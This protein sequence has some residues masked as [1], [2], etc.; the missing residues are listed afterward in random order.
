MLNG[1]DTKLV[2]YYPAATLAGCV[3][4]WTFDGTKDILTAPAQSGNYTNAMPG[5]TFGHRLTQLQFFPYA[6]DADAATLW[7]KVTAIKITGQ[8]TTCTFTPASADAT[9]AVAF[10]GNASALT[11]AGG[12]ATAPAVGTAAATRFGEPMMVEPQAGSYELTVTVTTENGERTMK[13]PAR[14]YPAGVATKVY[15]KLTAYSIE[16]T[17][18]ITAWGTAGSGTGTGD[19]NFD[20]ELMVDLSKGGTA[21]CYIA[22]RV[23]LEYSFDATKQGNGINT[24][25]SAMAAIAPKSAKVFWQTGKVIEDGSVRLENG[26]VKF[27][28]DPEFKPADGGSALIAV[29]DDIDPDATGAKILWSWHIWATDYNPDGTADYGLAANS[30]AYVSGG[31][32]HTYGTTYMATNPGKVMMDRNLGAEKALYT[33]ATGSNDNWPTYGFLYQWGRK[34]PFPGAAKNVT[35]NSGAS[36]PLYAADGT[37]DI[38]SSAF[39]IVGGSKSIADAV[40]NPGTFYSGSDWT[41][42]N[43]N[44]WSSTTGK[45]TAYDPCPPGWRMALGGTWNDFSTANF[46]ANGSGVTAG[47]FYAVGNIRMWY[48][49]Q[50]YRGSS[51]GTLYSVGTEGSVWSGSI[52]GSAAWDFW[53]NLS[54][55]QSKGSGNRATSFPLRCIQE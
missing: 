22:N 11:V 31:Q 16:P 3:V 35:G 10:S 50:G 23:G 51:N 39:K 42:R 34:D 47:R 44:L 45:K 6:T 36:R 29:Y 46:V 18:E 14:T 9:G 20:P 43:D 8:R 17:A 54:G 13:V 2:G 28:L 49:V 33:L 26:R 25:G 37:T 41:S 52:N 40:A 53:F 27:F 32:V 5:F 4:S 7:G 48:P 24:D 55:V 1:L 30:K 15:L 21:N 19:D 12:S 38:T